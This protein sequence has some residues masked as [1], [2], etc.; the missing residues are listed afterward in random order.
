MVLLQTPASR[1]SNLQRLA[2]THQGCQGSRGAATDRRYAAPHCP[3]TSPQMAKPWKG[4]TLSP[5]V[6]SGSSQRW[7]PQC[8]LQ[9]SCAASLPTLSKQWVADSSQP[10]GGLTVVQGAIKIRDYS[11]LQISY[12]AHPSC[13]AV[14]FRSESAAAARCKGWIRSEVG[15][16][17]SRL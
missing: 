12:T 10:G 1:H 14:E 17:T 16:C 8:W 6:P 5:P 11:R 15:V 4:G 13:L 9:Q 2:V 7:A 3:R